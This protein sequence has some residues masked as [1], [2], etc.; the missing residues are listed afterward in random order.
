MYVYMI[1]R[2]GVYDPIMFRCGGVFAKLRNCQTVL[3]DDCNGVD[4]HV[5]VMTLGFC[6]N[7]VIWTYLTYVFFQYVRVTATLYIRQWAERYNGGN[8]RLMFDPSIGV[9]AVLVFHA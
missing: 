4:D 9:S 6:F 3:N 1:C 2:S 7:F 5:S 8:I